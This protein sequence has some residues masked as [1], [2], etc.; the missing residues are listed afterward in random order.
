[1]NKKITIGQLSQRVGLPAK[2]IRFYEEQGVIVPAQRD[3]NGYRMYSPSA[4]EEIFLIKN[5]RDL[6][7]PLSEIKKLI[8]GCNSQEDCQH[9]QKYIESEIEEYLIKL[10]AQIAQ[11]QTLE[12]KLSNLKSHV[13]E[14]PDCQDKK[15]GC[16][17]LH[18]LVSPSPLERTRDEKGHI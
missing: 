1:M 2:T 10:R 12:K 11:F 7:L 13:C 5:A 6:G 3:D 9:T 17:I 18:Q 4:V 15:Y 8:V 16:N 14:D